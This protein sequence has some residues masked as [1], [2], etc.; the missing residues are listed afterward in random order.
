MAKITASA[1]VRPLVQGP[2]V[3]VGAVLGEQAVAI[4]VTDEQIERGYKSAWHLLIAAVGIYELRNHKT[5]LSKILACGLIAFHTDAAVCD[6]LGTPTA[7]QK[8]LYRMRGSR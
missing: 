1:S 3:R 4:K 8:L 2:L 5:T 7:L 6:A